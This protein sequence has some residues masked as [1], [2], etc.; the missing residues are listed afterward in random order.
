MRS[1]DYLLLTFIDY[2]VIA[3]SMYLAPL[4][5]HGI[6]VRKYIMITCSV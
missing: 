4:Y 2:P 5:F 3:A 1:I 6:V